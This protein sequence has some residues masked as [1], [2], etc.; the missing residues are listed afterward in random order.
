M[1]LLSRYG[2]LSQE[3]LSIYCKVIQAKYQVLNSNLEDICVELHPL[4]KLAGSG[5]SDQ[6]NVYPS[7]EVMKIRFWIST[8]MLL[9]QV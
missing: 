2:T 5:M 4:T 6:A 8:S 3:N 9:E 7:S 1:I